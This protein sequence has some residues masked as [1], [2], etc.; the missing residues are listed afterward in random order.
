MLITK[1]QV[2]AYPKA[3]GIIF[4]MG[5]VCRDSP[6]RQ[7]SVGGLETDTPWGNCSQDALIP[8]PYPAQLSCTTMAVFYFYPR[9]RIRVLGCQLLKNPPFPFFGPSLGKLLARTWVRLTFHFPGE[10]C[11]QSYFEETVP[12]GTPC[13]LSQDP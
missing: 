7:G 10:V 1:A 2:G 3:P 6:S 13:S 12:C 4:W 8:H 9:F 11:L 5:R